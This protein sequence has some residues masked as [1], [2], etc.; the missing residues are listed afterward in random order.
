MMRLFIYQGRNSET[1][2]LVNVACDKSLVGQIVDV[3]SLKQKV[4]V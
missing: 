2:K 1:Q 4:L 3:K